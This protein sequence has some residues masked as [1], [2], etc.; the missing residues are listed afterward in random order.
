MKHNEHHWYQFKRF[1]WKFWK[2]K[3]S[4]WCKTFINIRSSLQIRLPF[5]FVYAKIT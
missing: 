3:P 1:V 2:L 4:S 5:C